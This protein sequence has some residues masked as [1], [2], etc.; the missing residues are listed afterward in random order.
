MTGYDEQTRK[1][2][3]L[4]A[5]LASFGFELRGERAAAKGNVV[6]E[7]TDREAFDVAVT[8]FVGNHLISGE[9]RFGNADIDRLINYII[10]SV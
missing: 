7:I 4:L 6:V 10:A 8:H 9:D 2:D 1:S 3:A 5:R